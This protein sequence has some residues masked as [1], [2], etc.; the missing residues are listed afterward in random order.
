MLDKIQA[1]IAQH[2]RY[3]DKRFRE[4]TRSG[5]ALLDVV[6]SYMLRKKGK[7]VRPMLVFLSAGLHGEINDRSYRAAVL[8]ELLHTATLLH[9]DVVD[10]ATKRRGLF[11]LNSIWKNK[12]AILVG[13]FLL[14]RGLLLSLRHED[15]TLLHL[16]TEAVEQMSEGEL[17]QVQKT[18]KL[19]MNYEEYLRIIEKKT[20][21]L[22]SVCCQLG[23][24][25]TGASADTM[26]QMRSLG[27]KLGTAFQM[28]DDLFDYEENGPIGKPFALDIQQKKITLPL[29]YALKDCRASERRRILGL[30]K[31]RSDSSSARKQ[32]VSFVRASKGI[33]Y[34][35]SCMQQYGEEA[36]VLLDRMP[37][38]SYRDALKQLVHFTIQRS[39]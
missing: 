3:F 2:M 11:S 22:F 10:G 27:Y 33:S 15:Y 36:L 29:L 13:D 8:I 31:H 24:S 39:S 5:I 38:S 6:M 16:V 4:E 35:R 12:V 26:T 19:N 17:L 9:D 30:L 20:A 34:T 32:I 28:R 18:R 7:R 14:S 21:S 23:A 25:S 1:P 37:D